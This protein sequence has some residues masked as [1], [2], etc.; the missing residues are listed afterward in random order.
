[1][2]FDTAILL[3]LFGEYF[4]FTEEHGAPA[5]KLSV[6]P[7]TPASKSL[8]L[9]LYGV[10]KEDNHLQRKPTMVNY[11]PSRVKKDTL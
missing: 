7:R 3:T 1:M 5:R 11:R 8:N 9:E 10:S 6:I 2:L 4:S